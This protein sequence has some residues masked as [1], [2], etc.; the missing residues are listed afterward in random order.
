VHNLTLVTASDCH[1]CE[2][3]RHVLDRIGHD[4]PFSLRTVDVES[5]EAQALAEQGI[6]LSFLPALVEGGRLLAYGRL[7]EKRLRKELAA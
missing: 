2:H 3:A 5:A 6:P 4:V 1:L 7:S